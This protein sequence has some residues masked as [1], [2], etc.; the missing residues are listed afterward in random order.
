MDNQKLEI[1]L[2]KAQQENEKLQKEL[3]AIALQL[4]LEIIRA[5]GL[6]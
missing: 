2:E 3:V 4:K 6:I 5:E 1:A